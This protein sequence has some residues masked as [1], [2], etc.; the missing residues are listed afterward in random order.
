MSTNREA[1]EQIFRADGPRLWVLLMG[2]AGRPEIVEDALSEAFARALRAKVE[3]ANPSAWVYTVAFRLIQDRLRDERRHV[4]LEEESLLGSGDV[5]HST[6]ELVAALSQLPVRQRAAL[7]LFYLED[8]S[9]RDIARILGTSL[10][11]V[12]VHLYRGRNRLGRLLAPTH[13]E[14]VTSHVNK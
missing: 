7:A 5:P 13:E 4:P 11:T 10:S 14:E 9:V 6:F 8:R 1:I 2:V 3:I 12:R